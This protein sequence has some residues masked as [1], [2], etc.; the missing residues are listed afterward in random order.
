MKVEKN[1]VIGFL[2]VGTKKL[3][4]RD[5]YGKINEIE[6]LC[7]LDFYVHETQQRGG[8]GKVS[9]YFIINKLVFIWK[10]VSL[11]KSKTK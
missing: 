1:S 7:V 2:K 11:W 8:H 10:N 4:I 6:P 9:L 3:F 5:D